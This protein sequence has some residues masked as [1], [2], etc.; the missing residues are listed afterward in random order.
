MPCLDEA[1][2]LP[3]VLASIPSGWEKIVVDNGSRDGSADLAERLGATVVREPQRGYGAAVAA[4]LAAAAADIVAVMDCDGTIDGHD[5]EEPVA[6]VRAGTADMVV[7]RRRPVSRGVWSVHARLGNAFLAAIIRRTTRLAVHD[8]APV[9]VARRSALV[10]LDVEDRRSG[11]PLELLLRAA[12]AGWR[13]TEV[14][15]TYGR[16]ATGTASKI[17]GSVRGTVT[18]ARD[19]G[20]VLTAQRLGAGR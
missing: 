20:R 13:V 14:D 5:L 8:L 15:V 18:V 3:G 11:Y 7:G 16:R 4:G 12:R 6:M 9:R 1:A 10:E 19:F 17:S 2:A